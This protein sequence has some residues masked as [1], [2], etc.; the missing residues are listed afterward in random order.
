MGRREGRSNPSL[1]QR[2][3]DLAYTSV[4][5]LV[6]TIEEHQDAPD[7]VDSETE[8]EDED[9]MGVGEDDEEDE[10]NEEDMEMFWGGRRGRSVEGR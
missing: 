10:E 5:P 7:L 3:A 2:S 4:S 8:S 6:D 1:G 9:I